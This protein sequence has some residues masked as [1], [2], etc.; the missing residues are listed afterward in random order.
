M[1]VWCAV[2]AAALFIMASCSDG[3]TASNG[4]QRRTT[5]TARHFARSYSLYTHCGIGWA[6]IDGAWW[7]SHTPLSDGNGNPPA[8]WGNPFQTGTLT[9]DNQSTAKFSSA[10]GDVV[11]YRTDRTEP[12]YIC[13]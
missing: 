12:P 8:G 7:R 2:L 11:F 10:P 6:Q 5:A 1:R 9:F 3:E 13:S 4:A